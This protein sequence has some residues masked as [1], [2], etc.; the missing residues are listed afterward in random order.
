[1]ETYNQKEIP[2]KRVRDDDGGGV[3]DVKEKKA[4]I[5]A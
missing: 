2:K 3:E 5:D 1:L 4:K